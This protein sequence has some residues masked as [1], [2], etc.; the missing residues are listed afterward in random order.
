[1]K[2]NAEARNNRSF[3][4]NDRRHFS[5]DNLPFSSQ[6]H[7]LPKTGVLQA[8]LAFQLTDDQL[9]VVE[10]AMERLVPV[11]GG[12]QGNPNRR[13]NALFL[14]C[15]RYLAQEPLEIGTLPQEKRP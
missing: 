14:L 5:Q 9:S 3:G 4:W 15:Q 8:D 6:I 11:A 1:M 12:Q 7:E 13:G 2:S 10:G